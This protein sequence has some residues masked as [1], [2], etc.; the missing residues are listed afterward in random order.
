MVA[1]WSFGSASWNTGNTAL[2]AVQVGQHW[3]HTQ[4]NSVN[5]GHCRPGFVFLA[6][7]KLFFFFLLSESLKE[8]TK[9]NKENQPTQKKKKATQVFIL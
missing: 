6:L 1:C 9:Q 2:P 5:V 7:L 3:F 8:K 4:Q